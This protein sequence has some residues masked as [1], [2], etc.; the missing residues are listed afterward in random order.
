M[1]LKGWFC[2]L[3]IIVVCF[4]RTSRLLVKTVRCVIWKPAQSATPCR[5][6]SSVLIL[7]SERVHLFVLVSI[8]VSIRFSWLPSFAD[9][10]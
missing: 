2:I 6:M 4:E 3:L 10:S 9:V 1:H 8:L 5:G 7:N